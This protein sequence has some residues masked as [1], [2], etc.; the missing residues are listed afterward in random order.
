MLPMVDAQGKAV[1][2]AFGR[3]ANVSTAA[4]LPP[5]QRP[6]KRTQRYDESGQKTRYFADDDAVDLDTLV[7]RT[8][9]GDDMDADLDR[10]VTNN[11]MRKQSF[12]ANEL[13]VDDEYEHDAGVELYES[14]QRKGT[15]EQAAAREKS[16]QVAQAQKAQKLEDQCMYCKSNPRR[17]VHLTV[18]ASPSC[19]LMLPP[20]GRLVP[21]HCCLVPSDHLP[22]IR[23]VDDHVWEEIK[24]FMKCLIRM[25]EAQGKHCIFF[26]TAMNLRNHKRHAVLECV[27]VG[28]REMDKAPGFF[29]KAMQEAE[30]EWS[31]HHAKAVIDTNAK[32]GLHASIPPNFP[33]TYV[34]F[35]YGTGYVHVIDDESQFDAQ[36]ARQVLVGLLRLPPEE[37]HRRHKMESTAT[38]QQFVREFVSTW[39]PYDW[40]LQL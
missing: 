33:Y 15:V 19:Y 36:F 34:Q 13:N 39:A 12:K 28:Q 14:R 5:G 21:G 18:S 16:R 30:S 23:Q 22:S 20:R 8:K 32:K 10:T 40:T 26:E 38:Q 37:M 31:Q 1:R 6:P 9:Y 25:Y 3:E 2:G 27:P 29:K 17:P 35:G 7:K 24:N 11:I 4:A